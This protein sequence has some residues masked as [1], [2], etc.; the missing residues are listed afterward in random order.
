[1][2]MP[3]SFLHI[4]RSGWCFDMAPVVSRASDLPE[5]PRRR[6]SPRLQP[7]AKPPAPHSRL[8]LQRSSGLGRAPRVL[9][10]PRKFSAGRPNCPRQTLRI[11]RFQ[12]APAA[13]QPCT[14]KA[15]ASW[16][17]LAFD[18]RAPPTPSRATF[19]TS[20]RTH[21]VVDERFA[22]HRVRRVGSDCPRVDDRR[23]HRDFPVRRPAMVLLAFGRDQGGSRRGHPRAAGAP[24]EDQAGSRRQVPR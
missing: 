8:G 1:M 12:S 21:H 11:R 19:R 4:I 22:S 15:R 24:E 3:G 6:P 5:R 23:A 2:A 16:K 18:A 9:A 14:L 20:R 17:Y 10:V 7:L 13:V